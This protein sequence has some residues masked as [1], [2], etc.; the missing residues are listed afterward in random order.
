MKASFGR[1][2]W[3]REDLENALEVQGYPVTEN[4]VKKLYDICNNHWFTD[5]MIEMGWN[6]MYDNI[7]IGDGWDTEKTM[8]NLQDIIEDNIEWFWNNDPII[9]FD[10]NTGCYRDKPLACDGETVDKFWIA[11]RDWCVEDCKENFDGHGEAF[12]ELSVIEEAVLNNF[13]NWLNWNQ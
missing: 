3:S 10:E 9:W 4:N 7:G 12:I 8:E 2:E 11:F 5:Y 6:Y 1:V 13:D